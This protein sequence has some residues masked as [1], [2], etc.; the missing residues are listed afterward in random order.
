VTVVRPNGGYGG[1]T[2]RYLDLRVDDD[3]NPVERLAGLVEMH[4]LFFGKPLP[5][6]QTPITEDIARELQSMLRTGGYTTAEPTGVWD[7][8]SKQAFWALVGN[9]N[10]EE[11]WSLDTNPNAIDAIAL[12]YLRQRFK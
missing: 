9:E 8:A 12:H 11:R 4:H 7:A 6:D 5:Q 1:D 2:D 3:P 10:L